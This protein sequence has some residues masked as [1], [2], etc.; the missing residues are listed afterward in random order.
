MHLIAKEVEAKCTFNWLLGYSSLDVTF[1]R[2]ITIA[3]AKSNRKKIDSFS[4]Y[5]INITFIW[6]DRYIITRIDTLMAPVSSEM[7]NQNT[8]M[9]YD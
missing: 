3:I 1:C 7:T 4:M 9:S 5:F 2:N 8:A 6:L